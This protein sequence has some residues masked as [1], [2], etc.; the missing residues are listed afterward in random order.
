MMDEIKLKEILNQ[1]RSGELH[2]DEAIYELRHFPYQDVGFAKIDSHRQLRQG[3]GEVIY[4]PKK[5][6]QECATLV[7]KLLE[8]TETPVLLSRANTEQAELAMKEN[9]GATFSERL[10]YWQPTQPN[11]KPLKEKQPTA[12]TSIVSAADS[13]ADNQSIQIQTSVRVSIVSAGTADAP[14]AEECAQTLI[15]HGILPARINDVGVAGLHRLLGQL[16]NLMEADIVVVVAGMEGALASVVGGLSSATVIAVPTSVGYGTSFEGITA[17]LSMLS[18]CAI[19][20]SVVGID[21]GIG[22]GFC[23]LRYL[24]SINSIR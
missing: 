5:T 4:A 1:I 23:A 15:A 12:Q 20:V 8:N 7:K 6:P 9:S 3:F 2:P 13:A 11:E 10:I 21:N 19:G 17:L 18:T 24:N 22:A 16:D 14:I